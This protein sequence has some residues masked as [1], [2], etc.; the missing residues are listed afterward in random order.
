MTR[1]K[2]YLRALCWASA[3]MLSNGCM[4]DSLVSVTPPQTI[5]DPS[6]VATPAGATQLYNNAGTT[7]AQGV[8]GSSTSF[9]FTTAV[10]TDELLHVQGSF[11]G[12]TLQLRLD[13]RIND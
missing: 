2:L 7:W 13:E 6:V 11:G 5:V 3:A 9:L 1:K 12:G 10:G 4:S 8:G